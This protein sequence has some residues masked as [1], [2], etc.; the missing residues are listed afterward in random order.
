VTVK[1]SDRVHRF[2]AGELRALAARRLLAEPGADAGDPALPVRRGDG[3]LE[4]GFT[5]VADRESAPRP[6]AVLIPL[7]AGDAELSVLFTTRSD[8]LPSHPGQISLPG[9][10]VDRGDD[11]PVAAA[12]RETFEET[13][14]SPRFV[15]V[16]GLLDT[17]QTRTGYR[18]V[19]VVGLVRPGFTL[20]PEPGEVAD[21]FDV[22]LRFL[23][24]KANHQRHERV[25]KG[26]ARQF[27][28]MPYGERYIWGATAGIIRNLYERLYLP[29]LDRSREAT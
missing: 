16:L 10:K 17:Y 28:A 20:R 4:A 6:A 21:I 12:L 24:D 11:G 7:V 2:D 9:G 15:D 8:E 1:E 26:R 19:P 27:Y 29:D 23:M 25:W 18:I 22:P 3:E 14:V 13:G 5:G